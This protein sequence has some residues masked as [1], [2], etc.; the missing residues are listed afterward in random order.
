[1]KKSELYRLAMKAVMK[2]NLSDDVKL[3]IIGVLKGN[4]DT[5]RFLE[6][7]EEAKQNGQPV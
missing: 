2:S 4:E 3:D 7:R 6:E 5:E 1:M